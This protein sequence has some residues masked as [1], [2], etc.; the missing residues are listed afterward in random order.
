MNDTETV[1]S[2]RSFCKKNNYKLYSVGYYH[3]WCDKNIQ[4]DPIELILW[5]SKAAFVFTDT[6]HGTVI[7][8]STG[9]QFFTKINN[10]SN[11]LD[12]LL[13]QYNVMN[14]KV[15]SFSFLSD[16]DIKIIDYNEE[17]KL[18]SAIREQSFELLKKAI[19]DE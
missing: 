3:K 13:K 8:L 5:F 17:E 7:S 6:F 14:R 15:N 1:T 16:S 11:K 9:A 19:S 4:A 12:Y 18:I 2:I 10:N